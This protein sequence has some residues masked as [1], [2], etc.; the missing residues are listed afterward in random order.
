LNWRAYVLLA[1]LGLGLALLVGHFQHFPGYLDSD[2]YFGGGV[3][4][5]LGN[6]F[7]QPYLWNYL[8]DPLGLPHPSH[9]YWMPLASILTAAGMLITGKADF[10][11]GRLAFLALAAAAPVLTARLAYAFSRKNALA[12]VSGL[13]AVFSI[14][15]APFM[16]V[17]DNYGSYIVLGSLFFLAMGRGTTAAFLAAGLIAGLMTLA[18][19][20]GLLWLAMAI[21]AAFLGAPAASPEG[22]LPTR[23][24]DTSARARRALVL[25]AL[26]TI[27]F[28]LIMA[29]WFHRNFTLYGTPMAPGGA[30]LL[31]LTNYDETF[32]YPASQLTFDRWLDQGWAGIVT[33]RLSALKWNLLNAFAAQGGVF[34]F[35]FIL[36]AAWIH[37]RDRRVH[38]ALVAW[39]A[40]LVVMS[41]VFPFAGARGGFFHAGAGMQPMWW[42][43]APLGLDAVVAAARRR[44]MFTPHAFTVFR[45]ALVGIALIMTALILTLRV[46]PGWGEGENTYPKIDSFLRNAGANASDIVMARNPPGYYMMTGRPAIA[47]PYSEAAD[48]LAAARRYDARY[49]VIESAGAAGPIK[50]V[51]EDLDS[52]IFEFLGELDG[53]RIF[54]IR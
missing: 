36:L 8:D 22:P 51:Y 34:L 11:S 31:W 41:L 13:L 1:I 9:S 44:G 2:Y 25:V 46:L 21:A 3:Q 29:P 26:A 18:R 27:G 15:Y 30:R 49:L 48:L 38:L 6:G 35:P 10:V 17:P 37:R 53:T 5:A 19:S 33:A 54:R 20:D 42:T 14:Y 39:A 32:V 40:L 24:P 7:T 47:V 43:L 16:P 12:L 4:L 23:I 45:G 52:T 50:S 28:L